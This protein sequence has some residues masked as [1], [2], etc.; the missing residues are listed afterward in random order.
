MC[1]M[2]LL[3]SVFSSCQKTDDPHQTDAFNNGTSE[4][5]MIVVISDMHLGADLAYAE[6]KNNLPSLEKLLMN[7]SSG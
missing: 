5:N 2:I 3:T 6:C 1:V 7:V 4:R